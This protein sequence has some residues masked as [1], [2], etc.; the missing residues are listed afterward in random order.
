[1]K[2]AQKIDIVVNVVFP[3]VAGILLYF[4]PIHSSNGFTRNQLPDGLWAYSLVSAL[5][6]T[7]NREVNVV[8]LTIALLAALLFELL[9]HYNFIAGTGD[10]WDC[11]TY[12]VFGS[13]AVLTNP[14]FL[15]LTNKQQQ[16]AKSN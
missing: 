5:L 16:D 1:M 13:A 8:W 7:W 2:N 6:M 14:Y 3:V 12:I 11:A 15:S 10:L 9:Q 4:S